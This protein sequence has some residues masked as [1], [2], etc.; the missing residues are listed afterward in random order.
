MA[1]E[2][3]SVHAEF[4]E[5]F[6]REESALGQHGIEACAA[7]SLA[8]NEA[9]AVRPVRSPGVH[10][11]HSPVENGK[12]VSH[13]KRRSDMAALRAMSHPEDM[14]TDCGGKPSVL[15]ALLPRAYRS[16][17]CVPRAVAVGTRRSLRFVINETHSAWVRRRLLRFSRKNARKILTKKLVAPATATFMRRRGLE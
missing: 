11:K 2:R 14:P 4:A 17:L 5:P 7:M 15:R 8:Q 1:R 16:H 3:C 6:K 13:R 10:A 9:I 12:H